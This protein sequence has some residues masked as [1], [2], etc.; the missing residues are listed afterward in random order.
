MYNKPPKCEILEDRQRTSGHSLQGTWDTQHSEFHTSTEV[1]VCPEESI[2]TYKCS[3]R[4]IFFN[5]IFSTQS[6]HSQGPFKLYS[7]RFPSKFSHLIVMVS[8]RARTLVQNS[9][10]P[11]HPPQQLQPVPVGHLCP[12][13]HQEPLRLQAA[14]KHCLQTRN[15]CLLSVYIFHQN[16]EFFSGAFLKQNTEGRIRVGQRLPKIRGSTGH[17][18]QDRLKRQNEMGEAE[19]DLSILVMTGPLKRFS[20]AISRAYAAKHLF[21][22]HLL[23]FAVLWEKLQFL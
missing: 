10:L 16:E 2:V 5:M 20:Q 18:F 19:E 22:C 13:G 12:V 4:K 23:L 11:L 8:R 15:S 21:V 9:A 14:P 7:D 3:I 6:N 17:N 1:W